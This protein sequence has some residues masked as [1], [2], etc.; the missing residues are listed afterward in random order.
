MVT[1]NVLIVD[2]DA[3]VRKSIERIL[4]Q[5]P[6]QKLYASSVA[7]ARRYISENKIHLVITDIMMPGADGFSLIQW[8][9]ENNPEIVRMVL[10]NWKGYRSGAGKRE[11]NG[12]S[13][14]RKY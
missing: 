9:R 10:S 2:D 1:H 5:E 4:R 6:Y 12:G 14:L 11:N 7:E 3:G 8:L 13:L